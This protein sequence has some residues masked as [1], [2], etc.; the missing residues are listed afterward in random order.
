MA[1]KSTCELELEVRSPYSKQLA[2][3]PLVPKGFGVLLF[4]G[5][6]A[7]DAFGSMQ[8]FN[9]LSRT[10]GIA[11]SIIV[12]TLDPVSTQWKGVHSI[13]QSVVHTHTFADA[14]DLALDVLLVPGGW[15]GFEPGP[16]LLEYVIGR[17]CVHRRHAGLGGIGVWRRP[18]GEHRPRD[19]VFED[20]VFVPGRLCGHI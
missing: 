1:S 14:P 20:R 19:G 7:L 18:G 6:E 4:P 12:V 3:C 16:T 2:N 10:H 15:S 9:D 8:V 17:Q 5:F 11:L 13:G